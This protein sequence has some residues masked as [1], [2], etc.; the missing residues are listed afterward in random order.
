MEFA[1]VVLRLSVSLARH[2]AGDTSVS[3]DTSLS[4]WSSISG[5]IGIFWIIR[6][7]LYLMDRTGRSEPA[8]GVS[9][10]GVE[11]LIAA[12]NYDAALEK[13]QRGLSA[14]RRRPGRARSNRPS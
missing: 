6:L 4:P 2:V 8:G 14:R 10:T 12:R 9:L 11:E 5:V 7:L 1:A 3:D 13:L